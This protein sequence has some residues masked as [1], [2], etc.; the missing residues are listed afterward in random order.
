MK[1]ILTKNWRPKLTCLI[2]AS[3]LW[4]LIS[5]NAEKNLPRPDGRPQPDLNA[6][7]S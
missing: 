3:V 7:K 5:K 4:Y 6:R 2:L 1:E